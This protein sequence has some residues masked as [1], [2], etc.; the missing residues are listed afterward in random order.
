[1]HLLALDPW[2]PKIEPIY[3][4][5]DTGKILIVV[6]E[7]TIAECCKLKYTDGTE[8]SIAKA[9]EAIGGFFQRKFLSRRSR[10][11][12]ESR[13]AIEYKRQFSVRTSDDPFNVR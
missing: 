8:I 10:T 9:K 5:A 1:M 13:L 4:L 12:E 3:D 2:P 6:S 7:I 11:D